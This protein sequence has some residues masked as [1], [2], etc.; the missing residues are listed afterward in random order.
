MSQTYSGACLCGESR[1]SFQG[2]S[3]WCAH[4]HCSLCQRAHGAPLVTWVGVTENQLQLPG[5][6]SLRWYQSSGDSRRGFCQHCGSTL[7]FQSRRWPG[8]VH[9]ARSNIEGEIDR[10]PTLHAYWDAHAPWFE[11][12]DEL[13]RRGESTSGN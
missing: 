9:I 3:L 1:F 11:F 12:S 6:D 7:F 4:C 2:P 13:P 8:E 5:G 10:E